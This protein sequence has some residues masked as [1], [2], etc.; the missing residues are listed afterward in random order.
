MTAGKRRLR[1]A[2]DLLRA[3]PVINKGTGQVRLSFGY[4]QRECDPQLTAT[5]LSPRCHSYDNCAINGNPFAIKPCFGG[6]MVT[7][8]ALVRICENHADILAVEKLRRSEIYYRRHDDGFDPVA[9]VP[10]S[11][12]RTDTAVV[13]RATGGQ[14]RANLSMN[15]RGGRM[16]TRGRSM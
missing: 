3:A 1:I 13:A 5:I 12:A 14:F 8:T 9:V 11:T 15:W 16:A 10:T 4:T 2:R 6:S 7:R